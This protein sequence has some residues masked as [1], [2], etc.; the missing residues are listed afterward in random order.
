MRNVIFLLS[1]AVLAFIPLA[2][3]KPGDSRP[4]NS[5]TNKLHKSQNIA[6]RLNLQN[7]SASFSQQSNYMA[8]KVIVKLKSTPPLVYS[9]ENS[10][11]FF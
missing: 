7:N 8:G 10:Q 3:L 1:I 9:N 2:A 6:S 11:K 5:V 4:T